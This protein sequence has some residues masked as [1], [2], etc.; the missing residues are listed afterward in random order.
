VVTVVF[1]GSKGIRLFGAPSDVVRADLTKLSSHGRFVCSLPKLPLLPGHYD[2]AI[3]VIVDRGL[4]D[5][6]ENVCRLSVTDSNYFGTGRLQ[7][8]NFG[9]VL[10]DFSWTTSAAA[11]GTYA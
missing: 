3:S 9:D 2:L 4:A 1:I 5:K 6:L 8:A 11:M 7:Q 10:V